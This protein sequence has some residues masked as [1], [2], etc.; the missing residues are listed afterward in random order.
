V[1]GSGAA[2]GW[3]RTRNVAAE[4]PGMLH[5][6]VPTQ[7]P[8]AERLATPAHASAPILGG[9]AWVVPY[10]PG[11]PAWITVAAP[12]IRITDLRARRAAAV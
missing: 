11:A 5:A 9:E 1:P 8:T 12:Q 3:G 7:Q 2:V 4:A 6:T 10:E